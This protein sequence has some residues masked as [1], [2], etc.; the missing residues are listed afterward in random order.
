MKDTRRYEIVRYRVLEHL[1]HRRR[2]EYLEEILSISSSLSEN[3][4]RNELNLRARVVARF[5]R[6]GGKK[7]FDRKVTSRTVAPEI[8]SYEILTLLVLP[9]G[10]RIKIPIWKEAE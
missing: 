7:G 8:L 4:I 10:G 6:T 3:C 9:G 2:G 1:V 5:Y